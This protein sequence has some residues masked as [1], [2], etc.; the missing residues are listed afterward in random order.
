[1][2]A[3]S[4]ILGLPLEESIIKNMAETMQRRGPDAQGC[5]QDEDTL[6]LH[7]RLAIIDPEGG[8]QPMEL[9][10][11]QETYVLVYNGEIYNTEELRQ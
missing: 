7:S 1:M 11:G 6:L 9:T 4:G 10:W 8:K 2:C 3:I 5:F